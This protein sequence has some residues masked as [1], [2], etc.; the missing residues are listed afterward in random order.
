[1]KEPTSKEK[2]SADL[3][4]YRKLSRQ[5]ELL[6]EAVKGKDGRIEAMKDVLFA[7]ERE[8]HRQCEIVKCYERWA[9]ESIATKTSSKRDRRIS[10]LESLVSRLE[11]LLQASE[12]R[13]ADLRANR[14]EMEV[15]EGRLRF[16]MVENKRLRTLLS[17][18]SLKISG[19]DNLKQEHEEQIKQFLQSNKVL[20]KESNTLEELVANLQGKLEKHRKKTEA[21]KG[22]LKF[23]MVENERLH[24]LLSSKNLKVSGLDDLKREHEKQIKQL[25][26]SNKVLVEGSNALEELVVNLQGKLEKHREFIKSALSKEDPGPFSWPG[27]QGSC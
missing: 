14:E 20:A 10:E 17:K 2:P 22:R 24:A 1:M 26:W 18:K 9:G 16:F 15:T 3:K 13:N 7:I 23:F 4:S 19:L 27:P 8:V 11:A 5:N 12:A 6:K 25:L 21:I